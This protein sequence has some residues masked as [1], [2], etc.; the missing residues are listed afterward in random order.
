MLPKNRIP[1]H[2]GEVLREEFLEPMGI[3]QVAFAEHIGVPLQ[4]VNEVVRQ[5]RGVTPESAWL[6]AAALGTT[7]EFW[8]H[9]QTAHDLAAVRPSRKIKRLRPSA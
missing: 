8:I 9:L 7:P 2:P 1:A 3:S 4:R 6:F 5:K